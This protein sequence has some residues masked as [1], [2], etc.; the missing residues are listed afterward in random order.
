MIAT[1]SL[2]NE[3]I[4][5]SYIILLAQWYTNLCH[6]MEFFPQISSYVPEIVSPLNALFI[7][8]CSLYITVCL[9][10]WR[11]HF[12]HRLP[13][14]M[15]HSAFS[16]LWLTKVEGTLWKYD[17]RASE[18]QFLLFQVTCKKLWHLKGNERSS[19]NMKKI[20][21]LTLEHVIDSFKDLWKLCGKNEKMLVIT[22]F[23]FFHN[24]M[25]TEII[26]FIQFN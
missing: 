23:T 12:F 24:V 22:I 7:R 26:I 1:L 20:F 13:W 2:F 25:K 15:P 11:T 16:M 17:K 4:C 18:M 8:T 10:F 6:L 9:F 21:L 19:H 3:N 14:Q 5:N